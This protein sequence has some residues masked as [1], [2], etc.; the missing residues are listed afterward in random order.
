LTIRE[1]I[2]FGRNGE[3]ISAEVLANLFCQVKEVIDQS[4]E[5]ENGLLTYFEVILGY[6]VRRPFK[7]LVTLPWYF[8]FWCIF[9]M[10]ME[11]RRWPLT[12]MNGRKWFM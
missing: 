6:Y 3:H 8:M 10:E 2:S 4:I 11:M 5:L 12:E 7:S 1:R 9:H